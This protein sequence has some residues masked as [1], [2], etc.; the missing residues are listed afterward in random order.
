M[1]W[2]ETHKGLSNFGDEFLILVATSCITDFLFL[3]CILYQDNLC[4]PSTSSQGN[5]NT[6][7]WKGEGSEVVRKLYWKTYIDCNF[8][9]IFFF[10][11]YCAQTIIFRDNPKLSN[12]TQQYLSQLPLPLWTNQPNPRHCLYTLMGTA[13]LGID[14]IL[15]SGH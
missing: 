6:H 8:F 2:K 3:W 1:L 4:T 12:T 14:Q 13:A 7:K 5:G 15:C 9:I 10:L 11:Y